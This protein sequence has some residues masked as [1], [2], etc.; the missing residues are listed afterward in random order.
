MTAQAARWSREDDLELLA[1]LAQPL[2]Q[3]YG[4]LRA[5]A[6]SH[7]RTHYA[8]RARCSTLRAAPEKMQPRRNFSLPGVIIDDCPLSY[9]VRARLLLEAGK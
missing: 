7:G 2:A 1:L 6:R 3:R 4:K 5:F 9:A 8:V